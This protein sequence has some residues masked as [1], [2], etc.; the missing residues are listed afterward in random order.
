MRK[1]EIESRI[2]QIEKTLR[3]LHTGQRDISK[4]IVTELRSFQSLLIEEKIEAMRQQ[5]G[6][7]YQRLLLDMVLSG[8]EREFERVCPDPC[9]VYNR[10]ECIEIT[11]KRL[12][13]FG[14]RLNPESTDQF[15][16]D[17]IRQ[18]RE[19]AD[20]YLRNS[21]QCNA[22]IEVFSLERDR[23]IH[24]IRD[25][26]VIRQSLKRQN[27][28]ILIS[29]LPEELVLSSIIEPLANPV[30]FSMIK[31]LSNGSMSFSELSA[32]T[33]RKGGHLLFHITRLIEAGLVIK[34]ETSGLYT[35]TE[36][37]MGVLNMVRNLYTC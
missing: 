11:L 27:H 7:G 12:R 13:E 15:I 14:E 35:L 31:A 23:M 28:D 21:Q 6:Q 18:D 30:R 34:S 37:S 10:Q 1:D 16:D 22:C 33:G 9:D 2:V 25:L 26:S 29:E 36:K 17:Q 8:A 32:L 20:R 3:D 4:T 5:L 24:A 19:I